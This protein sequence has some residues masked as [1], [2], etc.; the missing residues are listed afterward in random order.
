MYEM[1]K[2]P[3]GTI[4]AMCLNKQLID[5]TSKSD[6]MLISRGIPTYNIVKHY[7]H[8][9]NKSPSLQSDP[10]SLHPYMYVDFKGVTLKMQAVI[11]T[12]LCGVGGRG[13]S[14]GRTRDS[15]SGGPRFDPR[16]GR[17]LPTGWVG[18]SIMWPAET[19]VIVSH[20]ALPQYSLI[21]EEDVKKPNKQ[22]KNKKSV[23]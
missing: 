9:W 12:G 1:F 15:W 21:V 18:V 3:I 2:N 11:Y 7:G 17:L 14:V 19:E 5:F 4:I 23:G 22:T 8:S 16:C 6:V 13:S 10:S 20:R